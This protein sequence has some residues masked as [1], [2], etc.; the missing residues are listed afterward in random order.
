MNV[1]ISTVSFALNKKKH[2][3]SWKSHCLILTN[4]M[5]N[6]TTENRLLMQFA[7]SFCLRFVKSTVC[8]WIVSLNMVDEPTWKNR[9][10]FLPSKRKCL[11]NKNRHCRKLL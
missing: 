2:W 4:Q 6:T 9:I 10:I 5:E 1:K 11:P 7:E 3:K 8:I